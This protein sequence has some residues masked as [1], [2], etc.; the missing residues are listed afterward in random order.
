MQQKYSN[1]YICMTI[2]D[3]LIY[4]FLLA[5][6]TN[7]SIPYIA[8][9]LNPGVPPKSNTTCSRV[10]SHKVYETVN[11]E[12]QVAIENITSSR[13]RVHIWLP[14]LPSVFIEMYSSKDFAHTFINVRFKF[15][16]NTTA[17]KLTYHNAVN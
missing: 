16:G 12:D 10:Y 13:V 11:K 17:G 8:P 15:I 14:Q 6:E 4:Y 5:L 1:Y 7:G 9:T 2:F 3:Y